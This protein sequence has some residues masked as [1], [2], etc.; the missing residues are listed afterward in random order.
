MNILS[1]CSTDWAG[2]GIRLTDAINRNS[3]HKARQ[4]AL[5]P[6]RFGYHYDIIKMSLIAG[7]TSEH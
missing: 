6:H 2:C 7:Q 1:L 3:K 4:V 5:S